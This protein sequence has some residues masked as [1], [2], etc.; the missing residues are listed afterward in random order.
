MSVTCVWPV[1]FSVVTPNV[2][3]HG[4]YKKGKGQAE[5]RATFERGRY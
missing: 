1:N 2:F 4:V 5:R 3:A